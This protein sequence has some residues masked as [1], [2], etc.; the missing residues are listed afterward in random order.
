MTRMDVS[1]TY[2]ATGGAAMT[3]QAPQANSRMLA[4][5]VEGPVGNLF[6]KFAGSAKT[7]AAQ[8]AAFNSLLASFEKQ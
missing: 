3:Q 6:V 8:E 4:A 5:I 1:G 7:I 2:A